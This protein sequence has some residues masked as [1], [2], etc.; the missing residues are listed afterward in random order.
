MTVNALITALKK[1]PKDY[2][3]KIKLSSLSDGKLHTL[4]YGGLTY[5]LTKDDDN[6]D[7]SISL[8]I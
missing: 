3:F 4:T 6:K 2:E 7:I 8:I 5:T 1:C